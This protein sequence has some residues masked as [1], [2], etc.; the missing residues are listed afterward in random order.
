REVRHL[1]LDIEA[2]SADAELTLLDGEAVTPE[3]EFGRGAEW[4]GEEALAGEEGVF[5]LQIAG[6]ERM[7]HAAASVEIQLQIVAFESQRSFD[8]VVEHP[9]VGEREAA[10]GQIEEGFA[11]W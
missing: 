7:V 1:S 3:S 2:G 4:D 8:V 5:P 11:Q 10:N 6:V 9:T